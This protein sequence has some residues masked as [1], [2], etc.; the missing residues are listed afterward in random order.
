MNSWK[1][2][3]HYGKKLEKEFKNYLLQDQL[4]YQMYAEKMYVIQYKIAL[5][6]FLAKFKII[7]I[8]ILQNNMRIMLELCSEDQKMLYNQIGF[9]YLLVKNFL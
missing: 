8:F 3:D 9:I 4:L 5:C 7:L 6:M 1:R 2:Q